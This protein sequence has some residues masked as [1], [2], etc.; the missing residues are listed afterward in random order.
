MWGLFYI[1]NI[2]FYEYG[3]NKRDFKKQ[4]D[5]R[6]PRRVGRR[7][8]KTFERALFRRRSMRR[9]SVRR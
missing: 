7:T 2:I 5:C 3:N 6:Y 4:N 1:K 8:E 9:D